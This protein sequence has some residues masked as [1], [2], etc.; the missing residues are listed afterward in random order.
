MEMLWRGVMGAIEVD[1]EPLLVW[2]MHKIQLTERVN[3]WVMDKVKKVRKME[4]E[5]KTEF[6]ETVVVELEIY[7]SE[8]KW[9]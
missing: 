8:H 9:F 5:F 3:N 4:K 7:D 1:C 6:A 2:K